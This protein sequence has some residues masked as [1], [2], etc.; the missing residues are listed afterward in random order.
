M[1][2]KSWLQRPYRQDL[3]KRG[4]NVTLSTAGRHLAFAR[5]MIFKEQ[6]ASDWSL[7]AGRGKQSQPSR[8]ALSGYL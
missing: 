2:S 1:L 8:L 3:E 4:V 6:L 5:I 7:E